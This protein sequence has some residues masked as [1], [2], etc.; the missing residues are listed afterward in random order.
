MPTAKKAS[1]KKATAKKPAA[2]KA[3]TK[4]SAA[5]KAPAKKSRAGAKF[6]HG[7]DLTKTKEDRKRRSASEP[8]EKNR[9]TKKK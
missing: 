3:T 5:K 9:A 7:D 1:A 6:F 2:K 4:K 8:W